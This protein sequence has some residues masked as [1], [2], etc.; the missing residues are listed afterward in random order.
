MNIDN[1]AERQ[2]ERLTAQF[3]CS[4]RK[5]APTILDW[6]ASVFPEWKEYSTPGTP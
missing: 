3:F 2:N 4:L 1:T 5:I 6:D